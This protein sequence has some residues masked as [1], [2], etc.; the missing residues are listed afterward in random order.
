MVRVMTGVLIL[1]CGAL[2]PAPPGAA[3]PRRLDGVWGGD[4]IRVA[5]TAGDVEIQIA[6]LRGRADEPVTLDADGAFT[7]S[8]RLLPMQGANLQE[9][10]VR[11]PAT[12][13]GRVRGD[14]LRV[15][16]GPAG[17]DGAGS[18]VLARGRRAT[19][20]ECRKRG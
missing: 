16:V 15:E 2:L 5:A 14:E 9:D 7:V 18:Y 17:G 20:P 11:A 4:Q 8:L 13:H 12:V 3:A 1:T 19:L 6:C 10:D